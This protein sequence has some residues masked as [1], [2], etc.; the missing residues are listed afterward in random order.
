MCKPHCAFSLLQTYLR[1]LCKRTYCKNKLN[2]PYSP[3]SPIPIF[4]GRQTPLPVCNIPVWSPDF[5]VRTADASIRLAAESTLEPIRKRLLSILKQKPLG[6]QS[7]HVYYPSFRLSAKYT[8][9]PI[10]SRLLSCGSIHSGTNQMSPTI[11]LGAESTREPIRTRL[12][13]IFPSC[14]KIHSETNWFHSGTNQKSSTINLEAE[15]T[16]EPI[17]SLLLSIFLKN[18]LWDQ[19]EVFYY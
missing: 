5:P 1:Q 3:F 13:S 8:L 15:S 16:L 18:P 17:R 9:K 2:T 6:N 11:N 12:L 14:S 7:E 10:K 4:P 19:S